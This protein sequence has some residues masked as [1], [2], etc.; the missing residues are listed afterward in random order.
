MSLHCAIN[1]RKEIQV[2]YLIVKQT[3]DSLF[4]KI[5]LY[6]LQK[7]KG[8]KEREMKLPLNEIIYLFNLVNYFNNPDLFSKIILI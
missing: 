5:Y 4:C 2:F 1:N 7:R 3:R 8:K 6:D